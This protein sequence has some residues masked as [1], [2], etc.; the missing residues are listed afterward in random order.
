VTTFLLAL[1]RGYQ[2]SVSWWMPPMCRFHP[3]CSRYMYDAIRLWGPL[4][5]LGL[6]TRRIL[7]CHPFNPGGLDPVPLPPGA[8]PAGPA[9]SEQ[10]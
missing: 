4:R 1:I 10:A 8:P 5:G 2:R 6:G 7:R 3:S 9:G